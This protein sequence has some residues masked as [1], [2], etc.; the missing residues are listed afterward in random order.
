MIAASLAVAA[1]LSTAPV[2]AEDVRSQ[3]RYT[4]ARVDGSGERREV[5]LD[6]VTARGT[7]PRAG[8]ACDAI[9]ESGSISGVTAE[10]G[11]F[12]TM[13]HAPV[14]ARAEG[15]EEYEET[16]GNSCV[17]RSAKGPVFDF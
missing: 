5:T 14:T 6:C 10:S 15:A 8:E 7:H 17:L 3:D 13:E 9:A 12:C 1:V 4:L 16:F 11:A 2:A